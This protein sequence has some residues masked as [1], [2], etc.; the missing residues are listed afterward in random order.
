MGSHLSMANTHSS[1]SRENDDDDD[2]D[3]DD[4]NDDCSGLNDDWTPAK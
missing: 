4:D 2:D 3:D 1:A